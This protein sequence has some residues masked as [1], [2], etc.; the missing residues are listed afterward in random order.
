MNNEQ[1]TL[2]SRKVLHQRKRQLESI[3]IRLG[4]RKALLHSSDIV[5]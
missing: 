2:R 4:V 1:G 3:Q 5:E